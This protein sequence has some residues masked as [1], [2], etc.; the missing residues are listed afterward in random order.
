MKVHR[1]KAFDV[2]LCN[3]RPCSVGIT[4]TGRIQR[5]CEV[6]VIDLGG[7]QVR[8]CEHHA[9]ELRDLLLLAVP[10]APLRTRSRK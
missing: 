6:V 1:Q 9:R 3:E 4:D 7:S 2:G 8:V 5:S 10:L